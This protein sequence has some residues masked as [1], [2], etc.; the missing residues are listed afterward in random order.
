MALTDFVRTTISLQLGGVT[1]AGFG[2]MLFLYQLPDVPAGGT[3]RVSSFNN[4][5][6]VDAAFAGVEAWKVTVRAA[7]AAFF[8]NDLK[9]PK[10]MT[11]WVAFEEA[12]V[13]ALAA[14]L[15]ENRDWYA[16]AM[17]SRVAADIIAV[18]TW[19]EANEK[20]FFAATADADV[21]TPVGETTSV[22]Y[23]LLNAERKRTAL[24]YH[25]LAATAYPEMVWAGGQLPKSPGSITW[26]FKEVP[27]IPADTFTSAQASALKAKRVNYVE[28]VAGKKIMVGGF[29]SRVNFYIDI[30]RGLDYVVQRMNEDVFDLMVRMQKI[31]ADDRGSAMVEAVIWARLKASVSENIFSDEGLSVFVPRYAQR[32]A[33][34]IAERKLVG[35]KFTATLAGAVH[36]VEILGEVRT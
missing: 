24:V 33:A 11:A 3:P 4:L 10:F 31:P 5:A 21:L 9:S 13:D 19:V 26:A 6:E 17:D 25:S 20:L 28:S 1:R 34:D 35:C 27:G 32:D 30:V 23:S 14:A 18:A 15:V 36:E 8:S 12:R 29:V 22:A 2:T 7:A 16:L